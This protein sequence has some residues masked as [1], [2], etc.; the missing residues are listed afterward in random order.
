MPRGSPVPM[1]NVSGALWTPAESLDF[2]LCAMGSQ[3]KVMIGM[4]WDRGF[5]V[6]QPGLFP[7][8]SCRGAELTVLPSSLSAPE[9]STHPSEGLCEHL[10]RTMLSTVAW[11]P[12]GALCTPNRLQEQVQAVTQT[13]FKSVTPPPLYSPLIC[14]YSPSYSKQQIQAK[15]SEVA[16]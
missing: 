8:E 15:W 6:S 7:R 10:S 5:C 11:H 1:E 4:K 3:W 2:V 13:G 9:L 12:H 16:L 14:S